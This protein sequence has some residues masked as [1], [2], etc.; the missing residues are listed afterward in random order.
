MAHKWKVITLSRLA[1]NML[2]IDILKSEL[3]IYYYNHIL[4]LNI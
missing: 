1:G 3:S 2:G 4:K